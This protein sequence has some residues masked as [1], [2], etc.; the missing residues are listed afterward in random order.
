MQTFHF[1]LQRAGGRLAV[2][3]GIN[4][5]LIAVLVFVYPQILAYAV[6]TLFGLGGLSLLGFG[7]RSLRAGKSGNNGSVYRKT[8]Y[9]NE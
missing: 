1:N 4:L 9:F 5:L 3:G 6:A 8:N 2:F 7:L